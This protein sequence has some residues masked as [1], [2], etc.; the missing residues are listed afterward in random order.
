MLEVS[1]G[2]VTGVQCLHRGVDDGALLS[3][4]SVNFAFDVT[5]N[6]S[7]PKHNLV[8]CLH[9]SFDSGARVEVTWRLLFFDV[10]LFSH[11]SSSVASLMGI[12]Y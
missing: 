8:S 5:L 3:P 1:P 12:F 7:A 6:R 4:T 10:V 11:F 9:G 2:E